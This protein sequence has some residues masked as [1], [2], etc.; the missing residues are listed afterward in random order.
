[1]AGLRV[2]AEYRLWAF[3][4]LNLNR[5]FEPTTDVLVA[6]DTML[7]LT[8]EAPEAAGL[9][10]VVVNPRAEAKVSGAVVDTLGDS[11][12]VIR[13]LAVSAAD[14]TVRLLADVVGENLF[15]IGLAAGT[16]EIRAFRDLDRNRRF[17]AG[18]EPASE[19]L[20]LELEPAAIIADR[21]LVLRPPPEEP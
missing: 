12:G 14:T 4:D 6:V 2:P 20:R 18:R 15:D 10:V 16:W 9:S 5:S 3:A 21:T 17:D 8:R 1:M 11:L 7:T 19:A 13:V